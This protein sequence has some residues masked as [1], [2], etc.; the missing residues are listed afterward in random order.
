[1][2]MYH[3]NSQNDAAREYFIQLVKKALIALSPIQTHQKQKFFYLL[4]NRLNFNI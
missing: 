1:M 4:L 2:L 3:R